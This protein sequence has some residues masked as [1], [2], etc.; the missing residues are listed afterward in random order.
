MISPSIFRD[1]RSSTDEMAGASANERSIS[2]RLE[3]EE[4]ME[5]KRK[6]KFSFL[7][8][9]IFTEFTALQIEEN[10]R[11]LRVLSVLQTES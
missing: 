2:L 5:E 10:K 7:L 4:G 1:W 9:L 3:G 8:S 6:M 11:S